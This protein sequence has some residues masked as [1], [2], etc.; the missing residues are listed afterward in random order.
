[1]LW[2]SQLHYFHEELSKLQARP[3]PCEFGMLYVTNLSHF[4]SSLTL[5]GVPDG[6][7]AEQRGNFILN[8]N[9]RRMGCGGRSALTLHKPTDA[10]KDKFQQIYRINDRVPFEFGVIELIK[11]VQIALFHFG[12]FD[13]ANIDGLLCD[14]TEQA[15]L[16]WWTVI[17]NSIIT[18]HLEIEFWDHVDCFGSTRF[19][20]GM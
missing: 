9:L 13:L 17:G 10:S 12:F 20:F 18:L 11:L 4:P 16:E 19:T 1:M 14:L 15:V 2:T 7:V 8:E 5:I 6:N 3:K